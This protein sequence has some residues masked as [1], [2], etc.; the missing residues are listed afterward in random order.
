MAIHGQRHWARESHWQG[1]QTKGALL[2]HW[3]CHAT[4]TTTATTT[5]T[6]QLPYCARPYQTKPL[7][8]VALETLARLFLLLLLSS[9]PFDLFPSRSSLT[10]ASVPPPPPTESCRRIRDFRR[11]GPVT[12]SLHLGLNALYAYYAAGQGTNR[13]SMAHRWLVI[14]HDMQLSRACCCFQP[15]AR[16]SQSFASLTRRRDETGSATSQ[17]AGQP[18]HNPSC[19]RAT[20]GLPLVCA[21]PT[22]LR[23]QG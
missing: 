19:L 4:P 17:L 21:R 10:M 9:R 13:P 15:T 12:A 2:G 22:K 11:C 23:P 18:G 1:Q 8:P 5:T 20:T 3:T 16:D 6:A 7:L 14:S